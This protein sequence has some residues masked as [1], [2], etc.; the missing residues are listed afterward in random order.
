MS[1]TQLAEACAESEAAGVTGVVLVIP[2]GIRPPWRGELLSSTEERS[3][4]YLFP[5]KS[6]RRWLARVEKGAA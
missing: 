3:R 4:V 6:I 5:V 2:H 1:P